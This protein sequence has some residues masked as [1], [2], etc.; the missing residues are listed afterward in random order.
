MADHLI[1]P[2]EIE[3]IIHQFELSKVP[4]TES[5]IQ[6]EVGKARGSLNEPSEAENLGAWAEALAFG[7][8]GRRVGRTPWNTFFAPMGS[9]TT[10]DGT[11]VYFPDIIGTPPHVLTHWSERARK[12]QHPVLKSRYADLVWDM[13]PAIGKMRRDAEMARIAIDAYV[14]SATTRFRSELHDRF[15]ATLRALDLACLIN[16]SSRITQAREALMVLHRE[17]VKAKQGC[18]SLAF[19]RLM[20]DKKASVTDDERNELVH[21]LESLVAHFSDSAS[22]THFDPHAT[23]DAAERLVRHYGRVQRIEDAK[24]L[25]AVIARAFEHFASLAT[26]MLAS[27]LLQTSMDAY[28]KAGL[29]D[30]SRRIRILMQQKIGESRAEMLPSM[31]R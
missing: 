28:R 3:Q 22:T 9:G 13:N 12:L 31:P 6:Q 8:I 2:P 29:L 18:W 5:D 17:A 27:S 20:H 15:N 10:K 4:F 7:L 1:V 21:D 24:R 11:V 14:A 30:E 16:D 19:D 23:R 25:Y 26:A